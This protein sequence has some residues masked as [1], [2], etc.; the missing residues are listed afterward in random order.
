[1]S[2][3]RNYTATDNVSMKSNEWIRIKVLDK[4]QNSKSYYYHQFLTNLNF[5][6]LIVPEH[7]TLFFYYTN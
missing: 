5:S 3:Q 1:M 6:D 2:F 7:I 4:D